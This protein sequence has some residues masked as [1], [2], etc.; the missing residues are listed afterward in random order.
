[1]KN[2]GNQTPGKTETV[3]V[4]NVDNLETVDNNP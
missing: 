1:M 4:D 2:I 3:D